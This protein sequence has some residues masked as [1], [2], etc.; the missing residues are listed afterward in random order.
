MKNEFK[1]LWKNVL[2]CGKNVTTVRVKIVQREV[3]E[4]VTIDEDNTIISYDGAKSEKGKSIR[5]Y[6]HVL[7][8]TGIVEN[9]NFT[10]KLPVTRLYMVLYITPKFVLSDTFINLIPEPERSFVEEALKDYFNTEEYAFDEKNLTK[11]LST[12]LNSRE[13]VS[14]YKVFKAINSADVLK[15]ESLIKDLPL[16]YQVVTLRILA[17]KLSNLISDLKNV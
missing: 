6:T 2:V 1:R 16:E 10:G 17:H 5:M 9:L 11:Y 12:Y 13:D 15:V 14:A 4:R 3:N 8:S 7:V